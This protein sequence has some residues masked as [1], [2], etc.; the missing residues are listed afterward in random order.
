MAPKKKMGSPA[1]MLPSSQLTWGQYLS[2]ESLITAAGLAALFHCEL[3]G[4]TPER[5][6]NATKRQTAGPTTKF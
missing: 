4:R 5:C 2:F 1:C 3:I 6:T